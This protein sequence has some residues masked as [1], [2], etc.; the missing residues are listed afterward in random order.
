MISCITMDLTLDFV[1]MISYS[2]I[3]LASLRGIF[4]RR[5]S[6]LLYVGDIVMAIGLFLTILNSS[7]FGANLYR[8]ADVILTPAAIVWAII[9][10]RALL[11]S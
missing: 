11:K 3:I 4:K 5:F 1:R 6:N 10:Y 7:V 2:V 9:H 8:T